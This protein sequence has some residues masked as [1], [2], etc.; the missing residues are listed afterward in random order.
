MLEDFNPYLSAILKEMCSRVGADHRKVNFKKEYWFHEYAW[1][2]VEEKKFEEWMVDYLYG[3]APARK[4]LMEI[5][6][7]NKAHIR[8]TVKFFL[9]NY[10]WKYTETPKKMETTNGND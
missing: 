2:Q 8:K 6:W 10:G 5:P 3:S 1:S 7:R 4:A 9:F